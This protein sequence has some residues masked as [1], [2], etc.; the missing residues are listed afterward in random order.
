MSLDDT[1]RLDQNCKCVFEIKAKF[2]QFCALFLGHPLTI[3]L[4]TKHLRFYGGF[5]QLEMIEI[6]TRTFL[7]KII[8]LT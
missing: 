2:T 7:L 4:D 3:F 5:F 8:I 1:S 6:L